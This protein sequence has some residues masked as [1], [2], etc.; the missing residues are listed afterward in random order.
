M[1][2]L[3]ITSA[4]SLLAATAPAAGQVNPNAGPVS[5][6]GVLNDHD[7]N[8]GTWRLNADLRGGAFTGTA[9]MVLGGKPMSVTLKNAYYENGSCIFRG[10]NGRNRFELRGKCSPTQ[11]GPGTVNGY[12]DMD[13]QFNGEFSGTLR[14]GKVAAR[15]A[16]AGVVPSA[17]LMCGMRERVGGVVAGDL[18]RYEMRPS[19]MVSLTL[20]GGV[21]RTRNASGN[22]TVSGNRIRLTS[23]VYAGAVGELRADSSGE[24]A[25]YFSVEENRARNGTPIVDPWNTACARQ[26]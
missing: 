4:L 2:Y 24:P 20:A 9:E 11:F 15:P 10:E 5:G 25:V 6:D 21:Y 3:I 23:G 14:W 19:S 16:A 18:P 1:R 13:R 8:K 26:R 12:Y 22:Y 17:K 7:G